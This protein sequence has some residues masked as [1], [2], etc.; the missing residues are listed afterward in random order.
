MSTCPV[1]LIRLYETLNL[2]EWL[3]RRCIADLP[4]FGWHM[5]LA[6][7]EKAQP[8]PLLEKPTYKWVRNAL[9]FRQTTAQI[10]ADNPELWAVSEAHA[11][12]TQARRR[13]PLQAALLAHDATIGSVA[14]AVGMSPLVAEAFASLFFD[15]LG[16]KDYPG[17]LRDAAHTALMPRGW[18]WLYT[19]QLAYPLEKALLYAGLH[20]T[21]DDVMRL[22]AC[23]GRDLSIMRSSL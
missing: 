10:S 1:L 22:D 4:H 21:L 5:A 7:E 18:G 20:G 8:C 2:L 6:L 9:T 13:V 3:R 16:R 14:E 17:Y 11:L 23:L 19:P 15:V 12:Y